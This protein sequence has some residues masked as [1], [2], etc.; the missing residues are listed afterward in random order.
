MSTAELI[1]AY[2][3]P[4]GADTFKRLHDLLSAALLEDVDEFA[5]NLL[6]MGPG[7]A[8]FL[9]T[10]I[11]FFP[12]SALN[13]FIRQA[14]D[15]LDLPDRRELCEAVIAHASLQQPEGLRPFLPRL[16]ELCPNESNCSENWPWR[17]AG[18][19]DMGFLLRRESLAVTSVGYPVLVQ[20]SCFSV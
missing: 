3:A 6:G 16:F 1:E 11:A 8:G 15:G 19:A 13:R 7:A 20:A 18:P 9:E 5:A 2:K 10:V 14:A 4:W 17:G 12:D